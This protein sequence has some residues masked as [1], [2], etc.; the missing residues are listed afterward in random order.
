MAA[1]ISILEVTKLM[2]R[3]LMLPLLGL[4]GFLMICVAGYIWLEG[5]GWVNALYWTIHPYALPHQRIRD[6][7]KIYSIAVY[8]GVFSFQ[9]WIAERVLVSLFHPEGRTAGGRRMRDLA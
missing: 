8:V 7:T 4:T 6:A 9:V 2:V 1:P 3:R 5:A